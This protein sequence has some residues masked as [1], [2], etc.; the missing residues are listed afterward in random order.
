M[1]SSL[2]NTLMEDSVQ[3]L[4]DV[5][6]AETPDETQAGLVRNGLLQA[7]PTDTQINI[8]VHPGNKD[9]RHEL[10]LTQPGVQSPWAEIGGSSTW[11]RRFVAEL[12]LYFD[13][14]N[15]RDVA[16][17]KAN[18]VLSRAEYALKTINIP[19]GTDDFGE[20]AYLI[21]VRDSFIEESGGEGTFIWRGE[22]RFEFLTDKNE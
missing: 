20:S 1:N 22:V 2:L 8:L 3:R 5:L 12:S 21:Q 4:A 18:I 19:Q 9:W 15:D 6:I 17:T 13:G 14:E 7:D 11:M 16:R 10:Y